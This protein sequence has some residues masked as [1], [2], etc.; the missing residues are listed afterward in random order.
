[1]RRF[2][3]FSRVFHMRR[4]FFWGGGCL[5][6]WMAC[7]P[8][9]LS[10]SLKRADP[11]LP[12]LAMRAISAAAPPASMQRLS[13]HSGRPRPRRKPAALPRATRAL[14]DVT[15]LPLPQNDS[16]A[17]L[18]ARLEGILGSV[19]RWMLRKGRYAHR[20]YTRSRVLYERSQA[21]VRCPAAFL[22]PG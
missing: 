14:R 20:F 2:L 3:P 8:I 7:S 5:L 11:G 17:T 22:V 16:L 13:E 9:P 19:P 12:E 15:R 18:L 6:S 1:M 10:R 21:T 4:S